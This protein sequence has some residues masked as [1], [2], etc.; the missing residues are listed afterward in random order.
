MVKNVCHEKAY[1]S[2]VIH[3]FNH[4]SIVFCFNKSNLRRSREMSHVLFIRFF[5]DIKPL[6]LIGHFVYAFLH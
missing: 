1:L 4:R 5:T 2:T 3:L 6:F